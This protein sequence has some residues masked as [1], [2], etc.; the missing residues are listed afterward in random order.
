MRNLK[1]PS[2]VQA[3]CSRCQRPERQREP[4]HMSASQS[5][6]SDCISGWHAWLRRAA[7]A[8][9]S[10]RVC[11]QRRG[12]MAD[13]MC[14]GCAPCEG[15]PRAMAACLVAGSCPGATQ[16]M[17]YPVLW[18]HACLLWAAQVVLSAAPAFDSPLK[19]C[20]EKFQNTFG[21]LACGP[22]IPAFC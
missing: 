21:R 7:L 11:A 5:C 16:C 6:T 8:L 12:V 3:S 14:K 9:S 19:P 10:T 13:G 17:G 15:C 4:Q 18:L 2:L 1:L 22:R 20:T